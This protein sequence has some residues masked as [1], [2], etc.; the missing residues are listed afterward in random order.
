MRE[1]TQVRERERRWHTR[2]LREQA[3]EIPKKVGGCSVF[4]PDEAAQ[5]YRLLYKVLSANGTS[6]S[7]DAHSDT[8]CR[9]AKTD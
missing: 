5:L 4:N 2:A 9:D 3:R 7:E 1:H 6:R 8:S